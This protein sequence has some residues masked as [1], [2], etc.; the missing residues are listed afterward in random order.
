LVGNSHDN[1]VRLWDVA[2]GKVRLTL[3]GH[4]AEVDCCGF[5][6]D[7]KTV[8]SGSKDKTIKM[9]D[10]KTGKLL[11]TLTG[12]TGRVESLAFS[13]DGKT[14]ATG[15]GGGDTSVRLWDSTKE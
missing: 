6:P 2:T 4:T 14:L 3:E 1:N 11:R 12:H 15:G 8:A 10:A 9:W 7:G 5:S 13:P